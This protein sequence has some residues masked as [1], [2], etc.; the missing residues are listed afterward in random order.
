MLANE[1]KMRGGHATR[2]SEEQHRA[3]LL[4]ETEYL[5]KITD[6]S[7]ATFATARQ[8]YQPGSYDGSLLVGGP[9][10]AEERLPQPPAT[11]AINLASQDPL[12]VC[13]ARL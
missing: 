2:L 6:E 5:A 12:Q 1:H 9:Y 7:E 3:Q 10:G 13:V 8:Q 11:A 4:F